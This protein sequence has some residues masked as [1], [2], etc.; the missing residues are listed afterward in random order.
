MRVINL[1]NNK[2]IYS[3]A[4]KISESVFSDVNVTIGIVVSSI[5]NRISFPSN[6]FGHD[7][8]SAVTIPRDC[9]KQY[10]A[11]FLDTSEIKEQLDKEWEYIILFGREVMIKYEPELEDIITHE[12]QH[13]KQNY[14]E[15]IVSAK[16]RLLDIV[17]DLLGEKIQTPSESNAKAKE[18]GQESSIVSWVKE[19]NDRFT[20]YKEKI[21]EVYKI[22]WNPEG[23]T[24]II[25][26]EVA[27]LFEFYYK[28]TFI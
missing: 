15:P 18:Q 11:L 8:A 9:W 22:I 24:L 28:K 25:R 2:E 17:L 1:T 4:Q 21:Q 5:H 27:D 16:D 10:L 26:P 7:S 6:R 14:F 12:M 23:S 19:T 3:L 13:I 20:Q